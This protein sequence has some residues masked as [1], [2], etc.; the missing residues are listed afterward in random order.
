MK[1]TKKLTRAH[2]S[3][4][5]KQKIK[6]EDIETLR[7]YRMVGSTYVFAQGDKLV[8][9]DKGKLKGVETIK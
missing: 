6:K 3:F 8:I 4:L 9:A 2:Y 5:E 7:F 1:Q